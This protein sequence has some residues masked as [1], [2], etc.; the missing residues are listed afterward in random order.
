MAARRARMARLGR[1]LVTN[2]GVLALWLA[3]AQNIGAKGPTRQQE[4]AR[5]LRALKM[6]KTITRLENGV[7]TT[8]QVDAKGKHEGLEVIWLLRD[9]FR[10]DGH[11][12][13]RL[14]F[15]IGADGT[16]M[17]T[18]PGVW[19]VDYPEYGSASFCALHVQMHH[20]SPHGLHFGHMASQPRVSEQWWFDPA[21]CE[22]ERIARDLPN[23][24]VPRVGCVGSGFEDA[25]QG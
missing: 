9:H 15:T 3:S 13:S 21:D 23:K 10:A 22:R 20:P 11:W 14:T 7:C 8:Y 16:G 19:R 6:H 5:G 24:G 25:P 12:R 4:V 17:I 1:L 2:L 18:G